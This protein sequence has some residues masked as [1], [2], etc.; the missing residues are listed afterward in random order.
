MAHVPAVYLG[1]DI[2]TTCVK[3]ALA[4]AGDDEA[5]WLDLAERHGF[6]RLPCAGSPLIV[7]S[8]VRPTYGELA[9]AARELRQLVESFLPPAAIKGV[10]LTG[11]GAR[12]VAGEWQA[13]ALN[14]LR[15]V[16]EGVTAL[17]TE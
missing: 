6:R 12:L 8:P 14:E 5:A 9:Q 4:I 2:G 11:L 16:A 7:I 10:A 1:V 13:S 3:V 17:Y 15:A